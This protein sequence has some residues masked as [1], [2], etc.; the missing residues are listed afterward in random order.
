MQP[1]RTAQQIA[2]AYSDTSVSSHA[3]IPVK[4]GLKVPFFDA[5]KQALTTKNPQNQRFAGF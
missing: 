1:V 3:F 4:D 2:R 5:F